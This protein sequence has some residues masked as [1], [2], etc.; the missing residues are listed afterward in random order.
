MAPEARDKL[1]RYVKD[2]L[3]KGVINEKDS[4]PW[5]SPG[6]LVKKAHRGDALVLYYRGLNKETKD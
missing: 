5:A 2:Q 3:H 6:I 4:G 1:E